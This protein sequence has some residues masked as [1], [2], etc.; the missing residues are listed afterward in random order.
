MRILITCVS[1]C[2][3]SPILGKGGSGGGGTTADQVYRRRDVHFR[4]FA[5]PGGRRS[6]IRGMLTVNIVR[7]DGM[8]NPYRENF[9]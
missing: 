8:N 2:L 5:A 4:A 9:S 1:L 3:V 7:L 6:Q